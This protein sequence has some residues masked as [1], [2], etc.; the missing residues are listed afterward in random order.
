MSWSRCAGI[1]GVQWIRPH[2]VGGSA[3]MTRSAVTRKPSPETRRRCELLWSIARTGE[4]SRTREPSAAAVRI[5]IS[6]VPPT[7]RS[8]CAP[9][10]V[11]MS[12]SSEPGRVDVEQRVQERHVPR[13][14]GEDRLERQADQLAAARAQ[15]ARSTG[16]RQA[17]GAGRQVAEVEPGLERHRVPRGGSRRRPR[18]RRAAPSWPSRRGRSAPAP[19]PPCRPGR[20]WG[21]GRSRC[22]AGSAGRCGSRRTCRCCRSGTWPA[23]PC[24]AARPP[25]TARARHRSSGP[26]AGMSSAGPSHCPP[27]STMWPPPM[28]WL[29]VRPPTRSSASSTITSL[30]AATRSRGR[31]QAGQAGPDHDDARCAGRPCAGSAQH[32]LR[33]ADEG[34]GAQHG[35]TAEQAATAQLHERL[36]LVRT[37]KTSEQHSQV[38]RSCSGRRQV[39]PVGRWVGRTACV[40]DAAEPGARSA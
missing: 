38:R 10:P 7:I 22:C 4:L 39:C 21:S 3:T 35:G 32:G 18:L 30:P 5:D 8:C 12:D 11:L 24:A 28:E 33:L 20:R 31:G 36:L 37:S 25:P 29:R 34:R 9:P 1:A 16:A 15:H 40:G 27:T 23:R 14:G 2:S 26:L 13:L 6:C 17:V 19:P